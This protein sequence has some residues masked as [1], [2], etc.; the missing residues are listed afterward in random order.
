MCHP[1]NP[2]T[3]AERSVLQIEAIMELLEVCFRTVVDDKFFQQI[4]S[5]VIGSCLSPIVSNI[6]TEHFEKLAL[7]SAQHK[8]W[9][10]L[11]YV[12]DTFVVWPDGPERLTKFPQTPQQF[13]TFPSSLEIELH[14]AIPFPDVLVIRKEKTLATKV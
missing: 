13:T 1:R 4:Y 10:W 5:V 3:L 2:Y 14:S 8:P 6:F 11:R 9:M 12:D 7:G